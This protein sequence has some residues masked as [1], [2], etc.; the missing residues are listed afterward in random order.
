VHYIEYFVAMGNFM[1]YYLEWRC[2]SRNLL[3][4]M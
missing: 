2:Q 1:G 4:G 3:R